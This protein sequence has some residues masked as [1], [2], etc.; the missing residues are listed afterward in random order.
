MIPVTNLRAG[1][2]FSESGNFYRVLK[3][4][5]QKIGRGKAIIRVRCRDLKNRNIREISFASG[6]KVEEMEAYKRPMEFVYAD[7]RQGKVVLSDSKTRERKELDWETVGEA[8]LKFLASGQEV[9]ALTLEDSNEVIGVDVPLT[10]VLRVTET[11]AS[12]KG[13]TA[14]SARKPAKLQSGAVIQ[15]PMF[16]K[17]GDLVKV[18]T[19]SGEYIERL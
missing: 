9:L 3:Y 13:D 5:H 16:I 15:V 2:I 19:E 12:E 17:I 7:P 11:T 4:E 1:T 8:G 6:S 14:G 18:N 10:V